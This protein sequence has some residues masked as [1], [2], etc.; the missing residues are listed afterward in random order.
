MFLLR[1]RVKTVIAAQEEL[2]A[3]VDPAA[4]FKP[5]ETST[6]KDSDKDWVNLNKES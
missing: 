3:T 6:F 1:L 4:V 5:T 2:K